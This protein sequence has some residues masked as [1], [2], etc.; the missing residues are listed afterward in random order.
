MPA[1]LGALRAALA[2]LDVQYAV[3]ETRTGQA[4][5]LPTLNSHASFEALNSHLGQDWSL[6]WHVEGTT[7]PV[8]RCRL[9]LAGVARDGLAQGHALHDARELAL[10]DALHAFGLA[11]HLRAEPQWAE[12]DPEDGVNASDLILDAP[13]PAAPA[14]LPSEPPRDPQMDRARKHLDDLMEQLRAG[15]LGKEAAL[16]VARHGGGY[17]KDLEESRA[18]YKE[19]QG[20]LKG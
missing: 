6:T 13:P 19:L 2:Q 20:L 15:G 18:I 1:D 4:R 12:Y 16:V 8:V 10:T 7:P 9:D 3:L 14:T 11:P 5:V 17:G